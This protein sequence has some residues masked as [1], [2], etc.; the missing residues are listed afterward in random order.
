MP[1][2]TDALAELLDRG[3]ALIRSV[4]AWLD[5]GRR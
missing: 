1:S 2:L 3:T 5:G 4:A